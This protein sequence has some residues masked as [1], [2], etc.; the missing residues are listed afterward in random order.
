VPAAPTWARPEWA[1]SKWAPEPQPA[2]RVSRWKLGAELPRRGL[3]PARRNQCL[4]PPRAQAAAWAVRAAPGWALAARPRT[5]PGPAKI[6]TEAGPTRMSAKPASRS[7]SS[8]EASRRSPRAAAPRTDPAPPPGEASGWHPRPNRAAALVV[9]KPW[10][11]GDRQHA[12]LRRVTPAD[13]LDAGLRRVT[14]ASPLAAGSLRAALAGR[15][16]AGAA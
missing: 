10:T 8:A 3:W 7:P 4:S 1:A 14:P 16:A 12:G 5:R 6:Q 13:P 11:E 2:A 15:P 9:P